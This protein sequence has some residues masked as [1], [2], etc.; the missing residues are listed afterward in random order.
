MS[1]PDKISYGSILMRVLIFSVITVERKRQRQNYPV[2]RQRKVSFNVIKLELFSFGVSSPF[3]Q[4]FHHRISSLRQEEKR[5]IS[6]CLYS[7]LPTFAIS[8]FQFPEYSTL[9]RQFH[10]RFSNDH[11]RTRLASSTSSPFFFFFVLLLFFFCSTH[12]SCARMYNSRMS[13]RMFLC[14]M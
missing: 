5:S 14:P 8:L 4:L 10:L 1:S 11:C 6:N 12:F 7:I 2:S 3:F 13:T 9:H